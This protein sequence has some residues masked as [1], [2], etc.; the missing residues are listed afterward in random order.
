MTLSPCFTCNT[1]TWQRHSIRLNLQSFS[2]VPM[3]M[4]ADRCKCVSVFVSECTRIHN[5]HAHNKCIY[6]SVYACVRGECSFESSR[7]GPRGDDKAIKLYVSH[8]NCFDLFSSKTHG[9]MATRDILPNWKECSTLQN[10]RKL[11]ARKLTVVSVCPQRGK[12]H[13][14][15]PLCLF[16]ANFPEEDQK[17]LRMYFRIVLWKR[18]CFILL[19]R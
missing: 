12:T 16:F 14:F 5:T 15:V 17:T 10:M 11:Q 13:P 9:S 8:I 7:F 18:I 4:A 3:Q 2:H 19:Y 6:V 1:K